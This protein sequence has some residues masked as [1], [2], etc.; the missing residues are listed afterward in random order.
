VVC[1]G[2]Q[3]VAYI[4]IQ[5]LFAVD[6]AIKDVSHAMALAKNSGARLPGME[7]AMKHLEAVKEHHG[8]AGDIAGIYGAVREEGGLPFEIGPRELGS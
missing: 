3:R 8:K 1:F 5:P 6:L 4:S 7:T 2:D